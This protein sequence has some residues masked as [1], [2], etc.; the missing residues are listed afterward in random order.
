[1]KVSESL[2]TAIKEN[3]I[4]LIRQLL[5]DLLIF[6]K[7]LSKGEFLNTLNY[8]E[9]KGIKVKEDKLIGELI[10]KENK[11]LSLEDFSNAMTELTFNFCD[12][13][14]EDVRKIGF[15]LENKKL[16][17]KREKS[18]NVR[19][20]IDKNNSKYKVAVATVGILVFLGYLY[21]INK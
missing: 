16:S 4:K 11:E 19:V 10:Y 3:D 21:W 1:M 6:D 14:I 9:N 7:D 12:E 2:E 15:Y 18:T 8:V 13:R 20:D 5:V 17:R